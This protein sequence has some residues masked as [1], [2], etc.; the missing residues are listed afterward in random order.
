MLRL[1]T[2]RTPVNP[3]RA[4]ARILR[5]RS[6]AP[7]WA[8]LVA[9]VFSV[10]S[11]ADTFV[12]EDA[13]LLDVGEVEVELTYADF[14]GGD[15]AFGVG[16][17]FRPF[18]AP[19]EF[20]LGVARLRDDGDSDTELE[21][22]LKWRFAQ[23]GDLEAALLPFAVYG[24]DAS[25]V[26]EY[27]VLLPISVDLGTTVEAVHAHVGAVRDREGRDT[28]G[29]W[30]VAADLAVVERVGFTVD[31]SGTSRSGDDAVLQLGPSVALSDDVE[32]SLSAGRELTSGARTFYGVGLTLTF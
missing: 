7:A 18:A 5:A 27:G 21:A 4:F 10:P 2:H 13:G 6:M 32:L 26:V 15:R 24:S 11:Q 22:A 8:G 31:L 23:A 28:F 20:G 16:S 14:R 1:D 12:T 9:V 19:L 3:L 29:V 30:A 25:R 17:T